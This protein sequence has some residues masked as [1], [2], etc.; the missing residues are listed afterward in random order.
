MVSVEQLVEPSSGSEQG[1]NQVP[2]GAPGLA[3]GP[4][5]WLR[6]PGPGSGPRGP[7]GMEIPPARTDMLGEDG[8]KQT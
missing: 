7:A 4:R 6:G 8:S 5:A 1:G 3:Q 2:L